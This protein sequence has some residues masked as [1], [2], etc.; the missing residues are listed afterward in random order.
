MD[1]K[2]KKLITWGIAIAVSVVTVVLVYFMRLNNPPY[3]VEFIAP[4][5]ALS[6][7]FCVAGVMFTSFGALMWIS[8]TGVLDIIGYGFKSVLYLFTP[9]QKDKDEGGFYEYKLQK[10]AK[11][12]GVP[13]EYL[14]LG[15]IMVIVS[16]ILAS[17][18]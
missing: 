2:Y 8:T 7:G 16:L 17:Y 5:Q 1:N 11:R 12:R 6:D 13:F 14:W 10:Q 9:M 15:V 4:I 18:V 3:G